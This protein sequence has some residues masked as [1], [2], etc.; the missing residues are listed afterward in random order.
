MGYVDV[1]PRFVSKIEIQG[2]DSKRATTNG[3]GGGRG[4]APQVGHLNGGV[5]LRLIYSG[6]GS[7]SDTA[8]RTTRVR[9]RI[10]HASV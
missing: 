2:L 8:D 1:A 5:L 10:D 6:Y 7:G 3:K 4:G 9:R